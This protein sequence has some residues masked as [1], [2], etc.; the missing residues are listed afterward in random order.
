MPRMN[1][2]TAKWCLHLSFVW[3]SVGVLSGCQSVTLDKPAALTTPNALGSN[4][5]DLQV[6]D[7]ALGHFH[8]CAMDR[9]ARVNCWGAGDFGQINSKAR[10][11]RSARY[12]LDLTATHL[13][14]GEGH[15]CAILAD[16][17]V[18]CWG[19]PIAFGLADSTAPGPTLLDIPGK[20]IALS[21]GAL[22]T[23]VI[24][25]LDNQSKV[26]CAGEASA[27]KLGASPADEDADRQMFAK[28]DGLGQATA[29]AAG[30][31]STCVLMD[32]GTVRC[33][34]FNGYGSLGNTTLDDG[35]HSL[36]CLER[37]SMFGSCRQPLEHVHLLRAGGYHACALTDE[38]ELYCWGKNDDGQVDGTDRRHRVSPVRLSRP[39]QVVDVALGSG[40][41]CALAQDGTV[42]CWGRN[43]HGQL[44]RGTVGEYGE[45]AKVVGLGNIAKIHAGSEHTCALDGNH[46]L[47]CWG[48]NHQW[49]IGSPPAAELQPTP[50]MIASSW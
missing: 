20:P 48:A 18:S 11:S 17:R 2:G 50:V 28:I 42:W 27:L 35:N 39:T 41:T 46:A 33:W 15:S 45:P 10:R 24:T 40:H 19:S 13:A 1:L 43:D 8:T 5:D 14:L 25:R 23:C 38:R 12:T 26:Y 31:Q 30:S 49:Q 34:G 21:A 29:I 47:Y 32:G 7:F 3:V 44:G 4:P 37:G 36:V 22:H 9:S 16:E 6:S